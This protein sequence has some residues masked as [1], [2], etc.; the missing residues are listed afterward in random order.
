VGNLGDV[1]MANDTIGRRWAK[2]VVVVGVLGLGVG[3]FTERLI[4][5][6]PAGARPLP[7]AP[8]P[9]LEPSRPIAY[10]YDTVPVT[11]DEF[12]R[13]L[14]DRGGAERLEQ[15]VNIRIIETEAARRK[16]TVTKTEM[17]ADLAK[18]LEGMAVNHNDFVKVVLPKYGKTLYEWMEDVVR[19][20]LLLAKMC[21]DKVTVSDDHLKIQ[22]ERLHGEKR[23]VQMIL[24]P[25]SDDA[26]SVAKI[27]GKIVNDA[28]E[29]D[30]M[31]RGQANPL[32]GASKGIIKPISR[33][34]QGEDK[35]IEETAF[36]LKANEVSEI[37]VTEQGYVILKLNEILPPN[38]KVTFETEKNKLYATAFDERLELEIPKMFATLKEAAKP[39]TM[40]T[41]PSE[42][43][44]VNPSLMGS[45]TVPGSG[46]IPGGGTIQQAGGKK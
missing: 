6:Q 46:G 41:G 7:V 4:G 17:E 2:R 23:V 40:Y 11:Q 21:R 34:L 12:G 39:K 20:R 24:F 10:L 19:P 13:F 1:A 38:D 33:H 29:F 31:A 43:K 14:M 27:R 8:A 28:A 44:T 30:S 45:I 32:L 3:V 15:F 42:W 5:Q 26:N 16:I 35:R 22:Y 18:T 25:K 37:L 36:K 9:A